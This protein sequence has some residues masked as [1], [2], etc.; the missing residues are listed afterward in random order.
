MRIA[1]ICI[2][3]L[4]IIVYL[5]VV[6]GFM[7]EKQAGQIINTIDIN[8]ADGEKTHFI[9][10]DEIK[11][12]LY[13]SR[14]N[15]LGER[16][17]NIRLTKIEENLKQHQIIK[18]A[19]VYITEKGILH[20]DIRQRNPFVR[21]F[22]NYGQSY[23]LDEDG[24][25]L[26]VVQAFSPHVLVINGNIAEPFNPMKIK[27]INNVRFDSLSRRQ[28]CI[29]DIFKMAAFIN[30]DEFWKSQIVQVYVNQTGEFELIPRVGSHIIDFGQIDQMEEKFYKLK[31]LYLQG[32]NQLGWNIYS[33][34][35]LKYENQIVCIKN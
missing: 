12:M 32:F 6:S 4:L 34:V 15:I 14:I 19:E 21:I 8:I 16:V 22:N 27:N 31:L 33:R 17:A 5:I 26:P 13:E 11:E 35:N 18:M 30:K 25:I 7:S 29:Y 2:L 1:R 24:N 3:W 20:V 28:R 10:K 9:D 23:Y